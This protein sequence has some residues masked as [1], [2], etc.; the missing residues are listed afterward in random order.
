MVSPQEG[1][2]KFAITLSDILMPN[3]KR[4]VQL[5][6]ERPGLKAREIAKHLECDRKEITKFLYDNLD[7][8]V[9]DES[10]CWSLAKDASFELEF[11]SSGTWITKTNFE[12]TLQKL[13][14]P[15]GVAHRRVVLKIQEERKVLICAAA[16][17][18]TLAN[19]LVAAKKNVVLDFS[20]N[21]SALSYLNRAGFVDRLDKTI[22]IVPRRPP[23]SA[24]QIYKANNT[25]LVELLEINSDSS[26]NVP[27]QIKLSF[28][29]AFGD[30]YANK[31]F[32]IFGEFVGNVEEHSETAIPGFAG[33][34]TY[35][36]GGSTHV[37]AV[38]SD[39]GK[40][41]CSTLRPALAEHFPT[42]AAQFPESLEAADP[43]L[44]IYAMRNSGLSCRGK[45]RGAGFNIS[46]GQA[47]KLNAKIT[48]RQEDFSVS[49]N[50]KDQ[51][52]YSHDWDL[53]LPKL[54]G[55]HIVFEFSLTA[56]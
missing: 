52:L 11:T 55:T 24:A 30:L 4:I 1:E 6:S 42:V 28:A 17:I 49:L 39:S 40:G 44:I 53:G 46:H 43:K 34:Q 7:D 2:Y 35:N 41:I 13:G 15:L 27:E 48:I 51:D 18:L 23:T 12:K 37:V 47:E 8:F 56:N 3:R 14:S 31:L 19:Q 50:Y 25:N 9:Q 33:L 20:E 16:R 22:K 5:L 26:I 10:F 45:G 29:G 54:I 36:R 38:I 21:P 32:T